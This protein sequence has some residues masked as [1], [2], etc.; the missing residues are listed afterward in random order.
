MPLDEW[1]D[2]AADYPRDRCLHELFEAQAAASPDRI[3]VVCGNDALTYQELDER[4]TRLADRLVALGSGPDVLTAI[5]LDRSVEMVVAVLGVLKSGGAYVPI[6]PA[7]PADR[8]AFMLE[9]AAVRA[10]VSRRSLAQTF[11]SPTTPMVWIDELTPAVDPPPVY[12]PP[13]PG[14]LAYV[15]YTSGSTG[16][17]KGVQIEHR[18]IVNFITSMRKTPGLS[19]FD[20]LL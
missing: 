7:Y 3:A 9:D 14:N 15:R 19:D 5:C 18:A 17:P 16:K 2:T 8:I 11:S 13:T 20:V 4:A 10:I 12:R 1:N 6:D